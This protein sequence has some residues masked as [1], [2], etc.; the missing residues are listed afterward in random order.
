MKIVRG[1][2]EGDKK[3]TIGE[4]TNPIQHFIPHC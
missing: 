3:L 2:K 1:V 4:Q